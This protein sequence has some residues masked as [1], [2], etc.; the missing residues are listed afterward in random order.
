MKHL[1]YR[2]DI[3]ALRG[4]AVTLVVLFHAFPDYTNY[5]ED[6]LFE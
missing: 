1:T 6:D 2:Q 4:L 3:D 5:F